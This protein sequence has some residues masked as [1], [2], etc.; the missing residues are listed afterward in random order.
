MGTVQLAGLPACRGFVTVED[1]DIF[2]DEVIQVHVHYGLSVVSTSSVRSTFGILA[3]DVVMRRFRVVPHLPAPVLKR[4][5]LLQ[6][7]WRPSSSLP[8]TTTDWTSTGC[9]RK[10]A[11][12]CICM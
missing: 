3:S 2:L 7:T 10:V 6:G 8:E 11:F 9:P 5:R 4:S 1:L 12:P